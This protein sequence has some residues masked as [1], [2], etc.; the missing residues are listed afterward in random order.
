MRVNGFRA[1]MAA[2]AVTVLISCGKE[3]LPD[4]FESMKGMYEWKH[5][6]LVKGPALSQQHS[7]LYPGDVGFSI[8]FEL[9]DKGEAVFYKDGNIIS[10]NAYNIRDKE[11]NEYGG[12]ELLIKLRGD[13][14]ALN[15][16]EDKMKLTMT[17][18]TVLSLDKFPFPAIG[19]VSAY[20]PEFSSLS[21]SFKRR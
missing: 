15:I 6:G 8:A 4:G 1:L 17:G 2:T 3:Q 21:N 16:D 7:T 19:D 11:T 13:L 5:T 18:D 14:S 12:K 20:K 10:T 9:N